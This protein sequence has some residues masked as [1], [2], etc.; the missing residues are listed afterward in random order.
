VSSRFVIEDPSP[1]LSVHGFRDLGEICHPT[2]MWLVQFGI[3]QP[4]DDDVNA[5]II[6][7]RADNRFNV[8]PPG[9]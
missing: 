7:C 1:S 3:E 8:L 2:A 4:Q 9:R 6:A 5:V